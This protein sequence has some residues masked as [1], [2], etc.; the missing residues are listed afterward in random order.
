MANNNL[1]EFTIQWVFFGLLFFSLLSFAVVFVANNN[2]DAFGISSNKFDTTTIQSKL[3]SV[4][5][6]T[7]PLLNITAESNPEVSDLGSRD[8]VAVSYGLKGDSKGFIESTT[9][10][11]GWI[12]VGTT[13]DI[14]IGIFVGLFSISS[15]YFITKWIRQGA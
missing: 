8:S 11:M 14:I 13:G 3:I 7:D 1:S 9:M 4:E 6:N 2:A 15:L 5:T 10:F 12:F